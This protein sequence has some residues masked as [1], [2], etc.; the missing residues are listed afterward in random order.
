MRYS[1]VR[2][3]LN[4]W[5]EFTHVRS[6]AMQK[7]R[8]AAASFQNRGV[9]SAM[10]SWVAT[11]CVRSH[12]LATVA[13]VALHRRSHAQNIAIRTWRAQGSVRHDAASGMQRAIR[14][15]LRRHVGL[16]FRRWTQ[17]ALLRAAL[18]AQRA[19]TTRAHDGLVHVLRG[20]DLSRCLSRWQ[21]PVRLSMERAKLRGVARGFERLRMRRGLRQFRERLRT[22][23]DSARNRLL[24]IAARFQRLKLRRGWRELRD[25]LRQ[26]HHLS[27]IASGFWRLKLRRGWRELRDSLRQRHH[28][29]SIASGFWRLKLR[30]GWREFVDQLKQI[31]QREMEEETRKLAEHITPLDKRLDAVPTP[32]EKRKS[33]SK[34]PRTSNPDAVQRPWGWGSVKDRRGSI[35]DRHFEQGVL[36]KAT[37]DTPKSPKR[38]SSASTKSGWSLLAP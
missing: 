10:N 15:C 1:A 3:A 18:T 30:R 38:R 37:P 31:R 17:A 6:A 21:L 36:A 34:P 5:L 33:N 7:L 16:S 28:L 27:S 35:V 29:S 26:R 13:S 32:G 25:S 24:D 12:A 11:V 14:W 8:G 2:C 19:R 4:S 9:R 23:C 22:V 20:R